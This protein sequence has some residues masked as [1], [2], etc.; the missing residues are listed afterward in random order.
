[1][2]DIHKF[3]KTGSLI[4]ECLSETDTLELFSN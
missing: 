3:E 2:P 4:M 1:M